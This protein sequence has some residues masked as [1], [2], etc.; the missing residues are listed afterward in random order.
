MGVR[1]DVYPPWVEVDDRQSNF[2]PSTG[3]FVVASDDAVIDGVKVGRLP[4]DLLE[5]GHRPA[6][7]VRLRPERQR[8]D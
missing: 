5:E 6:L 1:W 2:D 7:R 3:K 4:A 8:L